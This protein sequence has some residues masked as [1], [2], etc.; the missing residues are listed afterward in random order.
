MEVDVLL[1]G[2]EGD[3]IDLPPRIDTLVAVAVLYEWCEQRRFNFLQKLSPAQRA[4][5][6][7]AR[8]SSNALG[9][10]VVSASP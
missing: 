5:I 9:V 7:S 8:M 2:K 3:R 10:K 1:G 4:S 6:V